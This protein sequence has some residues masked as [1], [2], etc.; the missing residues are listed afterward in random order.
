MSGMQTSVAT[1]EREPSGRRKRKPQPGRYV[2]PAD[3]P[4]KVPRWSDAEVAYLEAHYTYEPAWQVAAA[5]G[6]TIAA[7]RCKAT[8]LAVRTCPPECLTPPQVA[9]VLGRNER[10]VH[11]W[12]ESGQLKGQR[13]QV[14]TESWHV[15]QRELRLFII[16]H[17]GEIRADRADILWLVAI[18]SGGPNAMIVH[19]GRAS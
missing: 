12:L 1:V 16:G 9:Q 19:R 2:R 18:V 6:K 15:H 10:T 7:V 14:G 13:A 5:L 3:L 17:A 11:R 4:Y 8:R